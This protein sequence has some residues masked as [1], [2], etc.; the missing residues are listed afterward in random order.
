MSLTSAAFKARVLA[1][2]ALDGEPTGVDLSVTRV[3]DYTTNW[4]GC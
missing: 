3:F 1:A 4:T 2:S